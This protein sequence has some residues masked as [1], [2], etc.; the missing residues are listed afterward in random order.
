MKAS[1]TSPVP[2]PLSYEQALSRLDQ[3]THAMESGE[4]SIDQMA[5]KI[6]EAQTL[7]TYCRQ[8]LFDAEK[9]CQE[10]LDENEE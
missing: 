9:K 5:E 3:I 1:D 4:V 10:L 2:T 7:L 8:K 6:Q